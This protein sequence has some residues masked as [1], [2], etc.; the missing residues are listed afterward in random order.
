MQPESYDARGRDRTVVRRALLVCGILSSLLYVVMNIVVPLRWPAYRVASQTVSELSA[1]GA[2]TRALW[3]PLGVAY[4]LLVTAFGCGVR[5]SARGNR[6]LRI[7]GTVMIV[8]GV[9]GLAWPPMHQ[10]HVLAGGGGTLTD[11]LHLTWAMVTVVLMLLAIGFGAAAFGT[12]FRVYSMATIA[13]LATFGVLTT[14]DAPRISANLP[15]PWA[16]V[17]ERVDI[18]VFLLWMMVLAM[19]LLPSGP[20]GNCAARRQSAP[21]QSSGSR[22]SLKRRPSRARVSLHWPALVGPGVRRRGSG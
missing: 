21:A 5:A 16:G 6:P 11:T 20:N 10:R 12:R 18:G 3:V 14:M 1:I 17:W 19:A 4:T 8:Y 13:V 2:P 9:I 7:V 22:R 15:T